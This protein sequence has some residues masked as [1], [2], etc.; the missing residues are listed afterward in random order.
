MATLVQPNDRKQYYLQFYDGN[1]SPKRR[2]LP[3][4]V[5][6]K[7]D[8]ETLQRKLEAAYAHG[9]FDPWRDDPRTLDR[10]DRMQYRVREA[11]DLFI[12][13]KRDAG[14]KRR[15]L[16]NYVSFI[17][18]MID[19]T[20]SNMLHHVTAD[21]LD[22]WIYESTVSP[23]TRHT[24]YRYASAFFNWCVEQD[25]LAESPL[26]KRNAPRNPKKLPKPIYRDEL[27]DL[28]ALIRSEYQTRRDEG[29]CR[30]GELIWRERAFRFA[31]VTGLRGGEIARLKWDHI[32]RDRGLIYILEQKN[33]QEQ[34]IPLHRKADQILGEVPHEGEFV[35]GGPGTK[36]EPRN[37]T[38]F[39]NNLSRA[40]LR[41]RREAGIRDG[42]SLHSLRH[43]FC[44]AL[45]EAGKSAATIKELARHAS[46]DTSMIYI[47]MSNEHLRREVDD[48][49]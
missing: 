38:A 20:G 42:I 16:K 28:C 32:D 15:T 31:F 17:G 45:A 9:E 13:A 21:V 29:Q 2:R 10:T 1:R 11:L 8:A 47:K 7:R 6:T 4:G 23:S 24:R 27:D 44:T 12:E 5:T 35:F 36:D 37:I 26:R 46:V 25:L 3:L 22:E 49:F 39:R 34:T 33:N 18:R 14:R 43:G 30:E 40:F 48:V 41:Y 19:R